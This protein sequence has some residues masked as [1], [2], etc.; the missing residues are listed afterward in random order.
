M[1]VLWADPSNHC[2]QDL[3]ATPRQLSHPAVLQLVPRCPKIHRSDHPRFSLLTNVQ[4]KV[5]LLLRHAD[6]NIM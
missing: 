5:F 4:K 6:S 3:L 2:V 1:D